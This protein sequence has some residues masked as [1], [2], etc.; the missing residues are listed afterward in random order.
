MTDY[1]RGELVK[2]IAMK[3][4]MTKNEDEWNNVYSEDFRNLY[5]EMADGIVKM[6]TA[7]YSG[8]V[9]SSLIEQGLIKAPTQK[10]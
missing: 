9:L 7:D 1:G 6:V 5:I 2:T 3:I 4:S 8:Y 10:N